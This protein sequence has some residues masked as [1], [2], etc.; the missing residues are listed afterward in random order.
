[1]PKSMAHSDVVGFFDAVRGVRA[2]TA[3][4]CAFFI[5]GR[6]NMDDLTDSELNNLFTCR[7]METE[8]KSLWL[9]AIADA[10]KLARYCRWIHD[11]TTGDWAV[12]LS[13][14]PEFIN[15][16]PLHELS[17]N[18]WVLILSYQPQLASECRLQKKFSALQKKYLAERKKILE[19][20]LCSK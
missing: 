7:Q 14:C 9:R 13:H 1:M 3:K 2:D 4:E 18:E 17:V 16:A 8:C 20:K 11:F 10:P 19:E 6:T 15:I 12:L 5:F